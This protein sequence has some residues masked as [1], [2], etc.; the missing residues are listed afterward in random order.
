[1]ILNGIYFNTLAIKVA[2]SHN[3]YCSIKSQF[4][5]KYF[6]ITFTTHPIVKLK[7]SVL[8]VMHRAPFV[9]MFTANT[10]LP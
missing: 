1:M 6:A 10:V 5:F 8:L 3:F 9:A 2:L 4:S 7:Y